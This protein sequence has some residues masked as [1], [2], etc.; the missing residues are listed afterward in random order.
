MI[1]YTRVDGITSVSRNYCFGTMAQ[2][3]FPEA[4]LGPNLMFLLYIGS[5]L[6]SHYISISVFDMSAFYCTCGRKKSKKHVCLRRE[7]EKETYNV[8]SK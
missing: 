6:L 5:P 2:Y 1:L 8:C 7:N 4:S 3:C